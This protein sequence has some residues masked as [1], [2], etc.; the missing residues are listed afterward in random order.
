MPEPLQ[1]QLDQHTDPPAAVAHLS[2]DA[3]NAHAEPLRQALTQLK[4]DTAPLVII[5][6]T[7]L[8][9]IASVAIAQL[10]ELHLDLQ[11]A[12]RQLRIAGANRQITGLFKT[13]QLVKVFPLFNNIAD[14]MPPR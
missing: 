14:A 3:S 6:L 10:I 5:D 11:Q 13:T 9:F 2:G 12:G 8:N 7:Q 1:I 4:Q